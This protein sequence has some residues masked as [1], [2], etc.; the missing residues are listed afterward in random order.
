MSCC[1]VGCFAYP[2]SHGVSRYIE[3]NNVVLLMSLSAIWH[4]LV[5]ELFR[6][7]ATAKAILML[8]RVSKAQ[9]AELQA[10]ERAVQSATSANE[11]AA[12]AIAQKQRRADKVRPACRETDL[13]PGVMRRQVGLKF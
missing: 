13:P 7:L 8:Q 5:K 6:V 12:T 2:F 4:Q 3:E 11:E 1:H 10:R 9:Q